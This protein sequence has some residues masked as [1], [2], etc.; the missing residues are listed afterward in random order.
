MEGGSCDPASRL[1]IEGNDEIRLRP[2]QLEAVLGDSSGDTTCPEGSPSE[3]DD[4]KGDAASTEEPVTILNVWQTAV[5]GASIGGIL[6]LI[7]AMLSVLLWREKRARIMLEN[8]RVFVGPPPMSA[9]FS[10]RGFIIER[11]NRQTIIDQQQNRGV[12]M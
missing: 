11:R 12:A 10:P 2:S 3:S 5:L 4:D 6:L 9:H 1:T 7:V 8:E